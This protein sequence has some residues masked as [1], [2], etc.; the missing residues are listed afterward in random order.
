MEY[1]FP[2]AIEPYDTTYVAY[3]IVAAIYLLLAVGVFATLRSQPSTAHVSRWGIATLIF[4]FI[5]FPVMAFLMQNQRDYGQARVEIFASFWCAWMICGVGIFLTRFRL[6]PDERHTVSSLL[7]Y[8]T[9]FPLLGVCC[10]SPFTPYPDHRPAFRTHCR[11]NLKQIGLALAIYEEDEFSLPPAKFGSPSMSWRVAVLPQLQMAT[12]R[13]LYDASQ[14]W[15][16]SK[17]LPVCKTDVNVYQCPHT[18]GRTDEQGRYLTD[19]LMLTG[20]G[21][22]GTPPSGKPIDFGDIQDGTSNTISVVESAGHRV[23]WT[24]PRD[25]DVSKRPIGVNL[26]GDEKGTSNG[27]VSSYH[28]KGA[29]VLFADGRTMFISQNIDPKVLK[30]MTTIRGGES[31]PAEC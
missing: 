20:A 15:D 1:P 31:V 17:N 23:V 22:I 19:Y 12:I 3:F 26:P 6:H 24:E 7:A 18:Y 29:H 9:L 28:T 13:E 11:N 25:M 14:F 10:F 21:A 16:H 27:I 4:P 5:C 2:P 8:V 30:A